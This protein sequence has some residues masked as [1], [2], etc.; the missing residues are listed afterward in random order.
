[1]SAIRK[2]K[3]SNGQRVREVM[4]GTILVGVIMEGLSEDETE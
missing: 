4:G 3:Q 1:M 2:M